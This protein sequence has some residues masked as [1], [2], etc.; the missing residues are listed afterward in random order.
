[1]AK[2]PG[3]TAAQRRVLDMIGCGEHC[4]PMT[5]GTRDAM[6]RSGLIVER[7]RR[8]VGRDR[9]GEVSI[10]QYE[11]PILVHMQWCEAMSAENPHA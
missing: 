5:Q 2:H 11:M 4:P 10:A 1:M 7:G 9:F 6:L 8:V 3:K